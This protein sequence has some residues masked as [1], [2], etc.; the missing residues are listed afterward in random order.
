VND[1]RDGGGAA[2]GQDVRQAWIRKPSPA[3]CRTSGASYAATRPWR[4]S[5]R[6]VYETTTLEQVLGATFYFDL[7]STRFGEP[8][9]VDRIR[10]RLRSFAWANSDLK[11]RCITVANVAVIDMGRH[12]AVFSTLD[13][14]KKR[15]EPWWWLDLS[16]CRVCGQGWLVAQEERQNDVV[17]MRRLDEQEVAGVIERSAWPSDFDR[18]ETLLRMG[19]EAGRASTFLDPLGDSSLDW[20]VADLA[21]DRPGIT[22]SD[23][24]ALLNLDREIA[25]AIATRVVASEGAKIR[26]D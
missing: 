13:E 9:E 26:F 17:C 23:L 22:V 20:T 2:A 11:C 1:P 18:Y 6:G 15:G 10:D 19:V 8:E 12:Q 25:E 14:R 21:R 16:V 7:I 5:S 3:S 4:T 24:C